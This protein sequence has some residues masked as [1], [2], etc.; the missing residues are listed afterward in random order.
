MF[1]AFEGTSAIVSRVFLVANETDEG[2]LHHVAGAIEIVK[3]AAGVP[4]ERTFVAF[5]E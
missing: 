2:L 5:Q 4:H 3:N 1:F